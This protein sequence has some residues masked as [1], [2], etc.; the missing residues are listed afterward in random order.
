MMM[1]LCLMDVSFFAVDNNWRTVSVDF[2]SL[3]LTLAASPVYGG[4][5][6]F[7]V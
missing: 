1:S 2:I 5:K 4:D 7:L 6:K 3:E